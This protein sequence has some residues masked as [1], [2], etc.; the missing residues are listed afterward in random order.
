MSAARAAKKNI[1]SQDFSLTT[2][3][4][5]KVRTRHASLG[6]VS[7]TLLSCA[8]QSIRQE[9]ILQQPQS[10]RAEFPK[11]GATHPADDYS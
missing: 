7:T 4:E 1:F 5:V 8:E 9:E 3:W 10:S 11:D 2:S 6:N